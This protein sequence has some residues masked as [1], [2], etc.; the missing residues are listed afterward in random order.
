MKKLMIKEGNIKYLYF[1]LLVIVL[2][3][4]LLSITIGVA[5]ITPRQT[6]NIIG[7]HLFNFPLNDN[8]A[9]GQQ[10]IIMQIRLPRI[11]LALLTGANLAV[12]GAIYQ[13]LFKNAMAD[14]FML[15]ISS[16]ASL[17]AGLGFML[18]GFVPFYAFIGALV[19]NAFVILLAGAKGKVATIRLLL[20]GMA[21]NY[22]FSSL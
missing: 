2:L 1:L 6:L 17:G 8:I 21:I 12:T 10:R 4:A 16:G 3:A 15:G 13:S 19:A 20:G 7:H 18:G 22:L 5:N 14:P 9:L 11:L